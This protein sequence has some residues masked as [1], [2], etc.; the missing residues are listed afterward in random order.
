[1]SLCHRLPC[2]SAVGVYLGSLIN[3]LASYLFFEVPCLLLFVGYI[4]VNVVKHKILFDCS[5]TV[6][7][8]A[9]LSLCVNFHVKIQIPTS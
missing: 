6:S 3:M 2:T 4:V 1:M 9:S 5:H 8:E 7:K